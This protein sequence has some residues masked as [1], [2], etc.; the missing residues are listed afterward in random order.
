M[1]SDIE[2]VKPGQIITLDARQ[3]TDPDGNKLEYEW[4][5]YPEI[6]G[7]NP[8]SAFSN[9]HSPQSDFTVPAGIPTIPILLTVRDSGTPSLTRY[10]RVILRAL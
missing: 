7:P 2:L 8:T 5:I 6:P 4:S 3:T 10:A 1:A 9:P